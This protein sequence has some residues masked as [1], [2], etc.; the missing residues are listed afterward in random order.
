MSDYLK[1]L[2]FTEEYW[3]KFGTKVDKRTRAILVRD[4][5]AEV[6]AIMP[7]YVRLRDAKD[8]EAT[9]LKKELARAVVITKRIAGV[10]R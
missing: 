9:V 8:P 7:T 10:N 1:S 2:A 3:A 5:V 6:E 4:L